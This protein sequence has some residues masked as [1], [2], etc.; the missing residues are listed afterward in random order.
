MLTEPAPEPFE[1]PLGVRLDR[2]VGQPVLDVVGQ[3]PR[4]GVATGW[5]GCHCLQADRLNRLV[6]RRVEPPGSHEFAP[7]DL[8]EHFADVQALRGVSLGFWF[9]LGVECRIT[10]NRAI[11][12]GS[13]ARPGCWAPPFSGTILSP[14]S[15]GA[16]EAVSRSDPNLRLPPPGYDL[17][18]LRGLAL[19]G[20]TQKTKAD[21]EVRSKY[22]TSSASGRLVRSSVRTSSGAD[23]R[24]PF[25]CRCSQTAS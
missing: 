5:L 25:A 7:L 19:R 9:L 24:S 20:V 16:E 1:P 17:S 13:H 15:R 10:G 12:W 4:S 22:A 23:G 8:M 3:G 11:R 21:T 18:P 2:L 14:A 6:D